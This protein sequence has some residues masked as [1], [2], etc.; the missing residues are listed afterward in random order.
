MANRKHFCTVSF[1]LISMF[2]LIITS[3]STDFRS[4]WKRS[5][6][7]VILLYLMSGTYMYT[8]AE[9]D[10]Q[11]DSFTMFLPLFATWNLKRWAK[12]VLIFFYFLHSV[13]NIS[14]I[15]VF[16]NFTYVLIVFATLMNATNKRFYVVK[17]FVFVSRNS[18]F[19][20]TLM[21]YHSRKQNEFTKKM[22][23]LKEVFWG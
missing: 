19:K 22:F 16:F 14:L 17:F 12:R 5:L 4:D 21:S 6:E 8:Y 7:T 9:N 13:S 2:A 18:N 1:A 15:F 3:Y 23:M 20:K 11:L 10:A